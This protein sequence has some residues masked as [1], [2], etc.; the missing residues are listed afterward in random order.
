MLSEE[1]VFLKKEEKG[2]VILFFKKF[3]FLLLFILRVVV[4]GKVIF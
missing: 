1:S 4:Y 2:K 3:R